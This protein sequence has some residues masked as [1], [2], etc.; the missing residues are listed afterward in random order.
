MSAARSPAGRRSIDSPFRTPGKTASRRARSRVSPASKFFDQ[1][2]EKLPEPISYLHYSTAGA[3]P[4]SRPPRP[5][6]S[7]VSSH[8]PD[9]PLYKIEESTSRLTSLVSD[10]E[11]QRQESNLRMV[12]ELDS[13]FQLNSNEPSEILE[14][15]KNIVDGLMSQNRALKDSQN[16]VLGSIQTWMQHEGQTLTGSDNFGASALGTSVD[17]LVAVL[18]SNEGI[19]QEKIS[20]A[21]SLHSDIVTKAFLAINMYQKRIAEQEKL[22]NELQSKHS[23]ATPQGRYRRVPGDADELQKQLERSQS[24]VKQQEDVIK[25]LNG[26]I[27]QLIGEM[28]AG[29][30]GGNEDVTEESIRNGRDMLDLE[31]KIDR[32]QG[33]VN[34]LSEANYKLKEKLQESEADAAYYKGKVGSLKERADQERNRREAQAKDYVNKLSARENGEGVENELKEALEKVIELERQNDQLVRDLEE[35]DGEYRK[36]LRN[37]VAAVRKEFEAKEMEEKKKQLIASVPEGSQ[38]ALKAL[39]SHYEE[40]LAK[41]RN[42]YDKK[43]ETMQKGNG[44]LLKKSLAEKNDKIKELQ[45]LLERGL[46]NLGDDEVK[47]VLAKLK[48]EY[49]AQLMEK[50]REMGNKLDKMRADFMALQQKLLSENK[51]KDDELRNLMFIASES[52]DGTDLGIPKEDVEVAIAKPN[53]GDIE[54]SVNEA[55]ETYKEA[56]EGKMREH[57]EEL[58]RYWIDKYDK[59]TKKLKDEMQA[60]IDEA[61]ELEN[62]LRE[63]IDELTSE[64]QRL[65]LQNDQ[66]ELKEEIRKLEEEKSEIETRNQKL[67]KENSLLHENA[68]KGNGDV[69][70]SDLTTAFVQQ[71]EELSTLKEEL[72]KLRADG[73][74]IYNS[75]MKAP[76]GQSNVKVSP[77]ARKLVLTHND[78][79]DITTPN[80]EVL[81]ASCANVL[82]EFGSHEAT[83]TSV[84]GRSPGDSSQLE[85]STNEQV[86]G[87]VRERSCSPVSDV[88]SPHASQIESPVSSKTEHSLVDRVVS[89]RI[90]TSSAELSIYKS[91]EINVPPSTQ[92]DVDLKKEGSLVHPESHQGALD[93]AADKANEAKHQMGQTYLHVACQVHGSPVQH[94]HL[95][96]Q[97]HMELF[98]AIHDVVSSEDTVVLNPSPT[99]SQ[100][101]RTEKQPPTHLITKEGELIAV[102]PLAHIDETT[103]PLAV[104]SATKNVIDTTLQKA[105]ELQM[106]VSEMKAIED[107]TDPAKKQK[108]T[109]TLKPTLDV[110]KDSIVSEMKEKISQLEQLVHQT[111]EK[112]QRG[113]GEAL[114]IGTQTSLSV[115]GEGSSNTIPGDLE[116]ARSPAASPQKQTSNLGLTTQAASSVT[117]DPT[118]QA[119]KSSYTDNGTQ[120]TA[121]SQAKP[122]QSPSPVDQETNKGSLTK[123][124]TT[125]STK[126]QRSSESPAQVSNDGPKPNQR[127]RMKMNAAPARRTPHRFYS[128]EVIEILPTLKGQLNAIQ[129]SDAP[130][131]AQAA[132]ANISQDLK[133][134]SASIAK[135]MEPVV[136]LTDASAEVQS[137]E[138]ESSNLQMAVEN[139]DGLVHRIVEK[140][141]A[142][143]EVQSSVAKTLNNTAMSFLKKMDQP[144]GADATEQSEFL[145]DVNKA[146]ALLASS[147]NELNAESESLDLLRKTLSDVRAEYEKQCDLIGSLRKEIMELKTYNDMPQVGKKL[148]QVRDD[149]RSLATGKPEQTKFIKSLEH[150]AEAVPTILRSCSNDGVIARVG[151]KADIQKAVSSIPNWEN[152][153]TSIDGA[154]D[155]IEKDTVIRRNEKLVQ[156][157]ND[158]NNLLMS[159]VQK[160]RAKTVIND[161]DTASVMK[162]SQ[163]NV[164]DLKSA[165]NVSHEQ[166]AMM[167]RQLKS[168]DREVELAAAHQLERERYQ[169]LCDEQKKT[170]QL[171]NEIT[172]LKDKLHGLQERFQD[173]FST[174]TD[175]QTSN[176]ILQ[177]RTN[178]MLMRAQ[179]DADKARA[180]ERMQHD[181]VSNLE[182]ATKKITNYIDENAEL[183]KQITKLETEL[184]DLRRQNLDL[185]VYNT[186]KGKDGKAEIPKLIRLYQDRAALYQDQLERKTRALMEMKT[187]RACDQ[188]S[189]ILINREQTRLKEQLRLAQIKYEAAKGQ[190]AVCDKAIAG[191]DQTIRELRRE[192]ERLRSLVRMNGPLQKKLREMQKIQNDTYEE[193]KQTEEE[194]A[195][196]ERAKDTFSGTKAVSNYFDKML[197]RN[198][199]RLAKLELQRKAYKDQERLNEIENLRAISQIVRESEIDIPESLVI[200][201]MPKPDP[202]KTLT[203]RPRLEHT[204]DFE[205][206]YMPEWQAP[207]Y[208]VTSY[209]DNLQLLGTLVGKKSPRTLQKMLRNA[210]HNNVVF[211]SA[212]LK[213]S[214]TRRR[215]GDPLPDLS[216]MTVTRISTAK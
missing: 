98:S 166:I 135:T 39:E 101:V 92:L 176:Q 17:D 202:V 84:S 3:S 45:L 123:S 9:D 102:P 58:E 175:T 22:I 59:E 118:N 215:A 65:R 128:S 152:V 173:M 137:F 164:Q 155:K 11:R 37:Q 80:R 114:E 35:K 77:I 63:R 131:Q 71:S 201:L 134:M 5:I 15:S 18:S 87:V 194:I 32:L 180:L 104:Q 138:T 185:S 140:Q 189:I 30:K 206:P 178:E 43:V 96:V 213:K 165:L 182:A 159:E 47:D 75:N 154:V 33:Q 111:E 57:K 82:H 171:T 136:E 144:G 67:E 85:E 19:T 148:T 162:M 53:S 28:L 97:P 205:K 207:T 103:H 199:D 115:T 121:R 168:T 76:D 93:Y 208:K 95:S 191:R 150:A 117:I 145:R 6:T 94:L 109:E 116:A 186:L 23:S 34:Q 20:K 16:S 139:A 184:Q 83:S 169:Q 44:D 193:I 29:G 88:P 108:L 172:E 105:S 124:H 120:M 89:A 100:V 163:A 31:V 200:Q 81:D 126:E 38:A 68:K 133:S 157:L 73:V 41:L 160:L 187:K 60:K 204:E 106:V 8:G 12:A 42:E 132:I 25:S 179:L 86:E 127:N 66:E 125:Q 70:L 195:K 210:R 183:Q 112:G 46:E 4:V 196:A 64:N 156:S 61:D 129:Q 24:R 26:R 141:S 153:V 54:A 149:L 216:P 99:R 181:T 110:E 49:D 74:C 190:V 146:T 48:A 113:Q 130:G 7:D 188:K 27:E 212:E 158:Q 209:A 174:A 203:K 14:Q 78:V 107:E 1:K 192:I 197:Q 40:E 36:K 52:K 69:A 147:V 122:E 211:P 167:E 143:V 62:Q 79:I 21:V 10:Y 119:E 151:A 161:R 91:P 51:Q 56:A 142:Q 50:E 2:L 214:P 90:A 13:C 198:R 72:E 170:A 177:N 55:I